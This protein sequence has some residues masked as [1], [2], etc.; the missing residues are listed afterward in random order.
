MASDVADSYIKLSAGFIELSKQEPYSTTTGEK[1]HLFY[2]AISD[3]YEKLRKFEGRVATDSDLKL[4]DTLRYY[5][6]D[7]CAAQDLLH[8]YE[9]VLCSSLRSALVCV[10]VFVLKTSTGLG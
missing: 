6:N 7:S 1:F 2:D 3:F 9:S 8:R 5:V 10:C 4:S